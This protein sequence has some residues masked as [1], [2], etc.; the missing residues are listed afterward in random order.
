M[1]EGG[2][3]GAPR[4][5]PRRAAP[6]ADD[7]REQAAADLAERRRRKLRRAAWIAIGAAAV[8]FAASRVVGPGDRGER[9][10][11]QDHMAQAGQAIGRDELAEAESELAEARRR[12]ARLSGDPVLVRSLGNAHMRLGS[13]AVARG[14]L[15]RAGAAFERALELYKEALAAKQDRGDWQLDVALA[16]LELGSL[17]ARRGDAAEV[18][19]RRRDAAELIAAAERGHVKDRSRLDR[20]RAQLASLDP[21]KR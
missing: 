11:I 1:S 20:V 17:A 16:T 2:V 4:A 10:A 13:A 7:E 19:R 5:R 12:L 18:E 8:A 9:R 6:T 14:D 15:P 21:A 3:G